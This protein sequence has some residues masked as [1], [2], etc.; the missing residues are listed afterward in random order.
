M[1]TEASPALGAPDTWVAPLARAVPALV[2][3]LVVTFSQDHSARL[4][5]VGFGVFAVVTAAVLLAS[6]LRADRGLRGVVLIQGVVTAAAGIAALVLP[7]GGIGYLVSVVSAWAIIAGALETVDGIRFRRTRP[8]A[9]DWLVTGVLTVALG[10]AFLLVPQTFADP[11]SVE[12]KGQTISG[13]VTADILLVGIL[14]AWAVLV[15]VQLAIAAVTLRT[16]RPAEA[17]AVGA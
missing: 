5:L 9:R 15:G 3:G 10:L 16:P 4:G 1:P 14:G 11:Y 12:D 2:L 8:A 6:G 13:T 7:G 17:K